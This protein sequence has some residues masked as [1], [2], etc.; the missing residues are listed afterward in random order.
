MTEAGYLGALVPE[1]YGGMGLDLSA[2][3]AILEEVN[4]SGA[5]AGPAHAQIHSGRGPQAR[6]R[7][8]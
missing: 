3:C 6:L 7:G 1:E 2:A 5:N 4:R 8:A